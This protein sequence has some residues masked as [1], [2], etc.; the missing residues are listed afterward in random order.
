MG[1]LQPA[2]P[3]HGADFTSR[4][5]LDLAWRR[6]SFPH[7]A[8]AVDASTARC[9]GRRRCARSAYR[10]HACRQ[11]PCLVCSPP[12]FLL[13]RGA[14][15]QW[16]AAHLG[17]WRQPPMGAAGDDQH[18]QPGMR[19]PPAWPPPPGQAA[20]QACGAHQQRCQARCS[21]SRGSAGA[22]FAAC[23]PPELSSRRR[24]AGG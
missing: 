6:R 21:V 10:R 13:H 17:P 15:P 2:T 9:A 14:E 22:P 3:W 12:R 7:P 24:S 1:R 20:K 18:P 23:R 8:L 11:G 19:W 4:S 16:R 5:R